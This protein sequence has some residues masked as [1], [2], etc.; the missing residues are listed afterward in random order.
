M[1]DSD[2]GPGKK[3]IG[4]LGGMGPYATIFFMKKIL[5]K[6]PA[7]NDREHI[8]MVVDN[9]PHIPSRSRAILYP[10]NSPLEGMVD[11]CHRL[12]RYPV[13]IIVLPCNSA[14]YW[15]KEIQ[16]RVKVPVINIIEIATEDL[17]SHRHYHRVTA[18]GG[19]VT[20]RKDTYKQSIEKFGAE[21][22][23][24]DPEDQNTVVE[25]IEAVKLAGSENQLKKP[26]SDFI[27]TLQKKY[28]I[29]AAILACT[30]FTVFSNSVFTLPVTDSST[31]LAQFVIDYTQKNMP[32]T[33]DTEK[34]RQFWD[35]RARMIE[36]HEIGILQST[37]LTKSEDDARKKDRTEKK[38]LLEILKPILNKDGIMLEL[39]CGTGRWS[40]VFS[41]HVKK[42]EAYD[43]C[44]QYITIAKRITRES[45]I[46][47]ITYSC[48]C[49]EKIPH[50]KKYDYVVSIA[51][52]HYLNEEQFKSV[53][54]LIKTTVK[55]D[56]YAI[57][58]ESFGVEKR[59]ELHGYHSD[60]LDTEYYAVY[61][62]SDELSLS[63][64]R[65]FQKITEKIT[66]P[67]TTDKPETFQKLIIF[68]KI[69]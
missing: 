24:I 47:N 56:G 1:P 44:H 61:R 17:F 49:V 26:F 45:D 54:R 68:K 18:L 43:Q 41:R 11:S 50:K 7:T 21:Y 53:I 64:G 8:H 46:D 63:L 3:I 4:I 16:R 15:I 25:F 32:L 38:I 12:E 23:K 33:L 67:E 62:T 34:I 10:E 27:S 31:A 66:L 20:Y 57:F 28:R 30:E 65:D 2:N 22:I 13:D 37:L 48:K 6:T 58:R 19:M 39:G 29:D 51:L 42:I 35:K 69:A 52:L 60:V 59:F 14:C 9:N 5:D 36:N 55:N 40:R